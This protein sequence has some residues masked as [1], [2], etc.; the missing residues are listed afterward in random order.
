M[1]M[2]FTVVAGS[3]TALAISAI[4]KKIYIDI[5]TSTPG[6]QGWVDNAKTTASKL[7]SKAKAGTEKVAEAAADGADAVADA[8]H[9]AADTLR[10]ETPAVN[11]ADATT[12][13][14]GKKNSV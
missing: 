4:S 10:P 14:D 6:D 3:L 9:K 7:R 5:K 1:K 12:D 11:D 13:A 8:A 2:F